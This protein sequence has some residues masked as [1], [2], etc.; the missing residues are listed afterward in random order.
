MKISYSVLNEKIVSANDKSNSM[1]GDWLLK[2]RGCDIIDITTEDS[3]F[4]STENLIVIDGS[5]EIDTAG[6]E[7]R[8]VIEDKRSYKQ[9]IQSKIRVDYSQE[10]E[11]EMMALG[12]ADSTDILYIDYRAKVAVAISEASTEIY[13]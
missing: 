7:A 12:I 3:R 5:I 1:Y 8:E 2:Q 6:I 9:L 13:S 10:D 11:F 4:C